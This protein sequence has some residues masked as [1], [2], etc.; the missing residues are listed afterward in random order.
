[1]VRAP[2]Q[3][4]EYVQDLPLSPTAAWDFFSRP[5]N[6]AQITPANLGFE[7]TSPLPERMYAG[8]IVSYRVRPLLGVAVPWTTEIVHVR[9]PEFFVDEQRSGPYRFWHHQHLFV[10]NER[11]VRMTD[12]VHY[13]LPFGLPGHAL[14]HGLVQ[15]RLREIFAYRRERLR[16]LF[17]AITP[18]AAGD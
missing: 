3:R 16:E 5:E 13:Q 17:G 6:L 11:G 7:V 10:P 9:E 18:S 4:L 12:L 2:V 1:M 14:L 8:L 15:S